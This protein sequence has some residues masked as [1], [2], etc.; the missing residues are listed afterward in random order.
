MSPVVRVDADV[1]E[2]LKRLARPLEDTPNSV[3]RRVAGLDPDAPTGSLSGSTAKS[4]PA[5]S[6]VPT[7]P[8]R[9]ERTNSG[10]ELNERWKVQARHA[11]YHKDGNYYN[12]L[13]NF[14]GALFDA[15]GYVLFKSE[16]E[17]VKAPRLQHGSQLHVAGGIAALPG[18]VRKS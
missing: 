12:H 15:H 6:K 9:R 10:R 4:G 13:R 1:W 17:Y 14:P 3:L 8:V 18:Y 2:W 16:N 5:R 7:S 11:L